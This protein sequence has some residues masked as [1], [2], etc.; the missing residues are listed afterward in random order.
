MGAGIAA[1]R[2]L[3]QHGEGMAAEKGLGLNGEGTVAEERAPLVRGW[4]RAKQAIVGDEGHVVRGNS[5]ISA[6]A[7]LMFPHSNVS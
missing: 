3:G 6:P 2:G 7:E 5:A 1:E 4:R